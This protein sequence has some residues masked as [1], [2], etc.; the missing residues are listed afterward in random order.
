MSV[1]VKF[2]EEGNSNGPM[3][4]FTL[5]E[6]LVNWLKQNG[7]PQVTDIRDLPKDLTLSGCVIA[8]TCKV[9]LC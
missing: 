6:T 2:R 3:F 4:Y 9:V 7:I 5:H 8:S 1:F